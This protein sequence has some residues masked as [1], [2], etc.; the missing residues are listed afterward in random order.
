MHRQIDWKN[1]KWSLAVLALGGV[2]FGCAGNSVGTGTTGTTSTTATTGGLFSDVAGVN[3]ND[4]PASLQYMFLTGAGRAGDTKTILARN[5]SVSDLFGSVSSGLTPKTLTLTSYESHN[6]ATNAGLL[7]TQSRVFN[8]LILD[9][10]NYTQTDGS[11]TSSFN[12]INNIP[13]ELTSSIRIFKGRHVQVP[14]Y[15]DPDTF[16]TETVNVNGSDVTQAK[17]DFAWFDVINK[18]EGDSVSVRSFLSD[19]VCYDVSAI[20][21]GVLP[22]LSDGSGTATRIFFSGDGFAIGNGNLQAGGAPFELILQQGQGASVVGRHS[23]SN[24]PGS[25]IPQ[26]TYTTIGVDP[27]DVTSTDPALARKITNFSGKFQFHFSQNLNSLTGKIDD[28]GYF[29]NVHSFEAMSFPTSL[30]DER[31]QVVMISETVT[32]N[33]NGTKSATINGIMW[34]YLDLATKVVRIYPIANIT[35]PDALVNRNGEVEGNLGT[36]FTATGAVTL[37]PQQMRYAEFTFAT[38]PAGFPAT[39]KIVVLRR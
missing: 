33:G 31:Q 10:K 24:V 30:D 29:K 27:S 32:T 17:F 4:T 19:Y 28:L 18:I 8:H 15:L 21:P 16:I 39:G 36:L 37:S 26:Y 11:G 6:L 2:L 20:D 3:L 9:V 25:P 1:I 12:S 14:L 35:D 7:N 13:D 34:G 23:S 38:P 5:L 22:S